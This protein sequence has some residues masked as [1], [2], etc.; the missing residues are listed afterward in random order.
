[1]KF[2]GENGPFAGPSRPHRGAFAG[3]SRGDEN[4][5]SPDA[6][7]PSADSAAPGPET[8]GY[9]GE[10]PKTAVHAGGQP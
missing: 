7:A 6:P 4:D 5:A 2:A 10:A 1:L 8:H 3:G 9:G